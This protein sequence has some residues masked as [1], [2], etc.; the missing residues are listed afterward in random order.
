M[1]VV[2]HFH[3]K[4]T[5]GDATVDGFLRWVQFSFHKTPFGCLCDKEIYIGAF[6][7]R[8]GLACSLIFT[9]IICLLLVTNGIVQ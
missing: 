9:L 3:G 5:F 8:Q 6:L 2:N 1:I 7:A 4:R